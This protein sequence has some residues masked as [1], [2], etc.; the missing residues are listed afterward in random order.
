MRAVA[1]VLLDQL[2]AVDPS[3]D[4]VVKVASMDLIYA[5]LFEAGA[6]ELS[7][8][9]GGGLNLDLAPI[10]GATHTILDRVVRFIT[11]NTDIDRPALVAALR[12]AVNNEL[13]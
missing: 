4:D 3:D 13:A 12:V 10:V 8:D 5:R 11:D 6:Y 9:D 7:V 1:E 2:I